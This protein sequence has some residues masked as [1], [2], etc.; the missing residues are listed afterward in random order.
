MLL[1]KNIPKLE[2]LIIIEIKELIK[3]IILLYDRFLEDIK[4]DLN[5][6]IKFSNERSGKSD[7]YRL[8]E[9]IIDTIDKLPENGQDVFR[10]NF[11]KRLRLHPDFIINIKFGCII[12]KNIPYWTL[13]PKYSLCSDP[14][15]EMISYHFNDNDFKIINGPP[16]KLYQHEKYINTINILYYIMIIN[17]LDLCNDI[18]QLIKN[19]SCC[20]IEKLS[21]IKFKL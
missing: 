15:V 4:S 2:T 8:Y 16:C 14:F 10:N 3:T 9:Y 13:L 20:D 17:Q 6:K 21:D 19:L 11:I 1:R 12:S 7:Q 18:K 5:I